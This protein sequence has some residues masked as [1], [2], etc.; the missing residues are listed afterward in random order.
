[1]VTRNVNSAVLLYHVL[2]LIL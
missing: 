2:L 1:M